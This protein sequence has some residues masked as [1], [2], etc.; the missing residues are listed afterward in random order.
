MKAF[1]LSMGEVVEFS[2][3]DLLRVFATPALMEIFTMALKSQYC[4]EN[5]QFYKKS[6]ALLDEVD[7]KK[8]KRAFRK[9]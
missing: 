5:L 7:E 6:R 9:I 2:D 3:A 4:L 1:W 8:M